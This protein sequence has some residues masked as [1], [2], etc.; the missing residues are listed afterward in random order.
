MDRWGGSICPPN[1]HQFNLRIRCDDKVPNLI[2]SKPLECT[3][4]N[5][6]IEVMITCNLNY[7]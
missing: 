4:F 6:Q 7:K 3:N 1:C 5:L 2:A